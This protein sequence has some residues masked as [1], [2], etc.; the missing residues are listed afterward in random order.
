MANYT[1]YCIVEETKNP[2]TAYIGRT[3]RDLQIR[4]KQHIGD[5]FNKSGANLSEK[6]VFIRDVY[7]RGGSVVA[8]QIDSTGDYLYSYDLEFYW[9][10]QFKQWG[11]TLL[12]KG[13]THPNSV[14][15]ECARYKI[16][17]KKDIVKDKI[18]DRIINYLSKGKSAKE[19]SDKIKIPYREIEC[20][21]D[22]MREEYGAKNVV[23]LVCLYLNLTL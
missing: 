22:L 12:N 6:A 16:K 7:K 15:P 9:I 2:T 8:F 19:I 5:A 14:K 21:I 23:Q 18:N 13:K 4:Y 20:H 17:Q 10:Q 1:I 11:Y 3:S